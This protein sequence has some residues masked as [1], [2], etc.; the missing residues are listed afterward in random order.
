MLHYLYDEWIL[1]PNT[2]A[3]ITRTQKDYGGYG[4]KVCCLGHECV[5][6]AM[7]TVEVAPHALLHRQRGSNSTI[8]SY[9]RPFYGSKI[10]FLWGCVDQDV[11]D[12]LEAHKATH[13]GACWPRIR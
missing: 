5:G 4:Q 1:T 7:E 12:Y 2:V 3:V 13:C 10:G 9:I 6:K 8:L 11:G